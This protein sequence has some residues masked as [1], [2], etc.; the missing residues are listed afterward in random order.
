[1]FGVAVE[2]VVGTLSAEIVAA[3]NFSF[4]LS[5]APLLHDTKKL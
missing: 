2:I 5:S 4:T 1:M 3:A